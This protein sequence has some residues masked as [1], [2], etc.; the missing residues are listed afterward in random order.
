MITLQ[1]IKPPPLSTHSHDTI[2]TPLRLFVE[3]R[4]AANKIQVTGTEN[5]PLAEKNEEVK[6]I[7]STELEKAPQLKAYI[8]YPKYDFF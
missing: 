7:A 5:L 3:D 2:K 4:S 6:K 1:L 8:K